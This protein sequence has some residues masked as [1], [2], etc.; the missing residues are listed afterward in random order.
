[1]RSNSETALLAF[2]LRRFAEGGSTAGGSGDGLDSSRSPSEPLVEDLAFD[3]FFGFFGVCSSSSDERNNRLF[4][5]TTSG[6]NFAAGTDG[7]RT[8]RTSRIAS[9]TSGV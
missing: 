6:D 2:T 7:A 4:V 9:E 3:A 5:A 8:S 1:V